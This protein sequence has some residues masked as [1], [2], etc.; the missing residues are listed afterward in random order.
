ML[1]IDDEERL[2]FYVDILK[3]SIRPNLETMR[4]EREVRMVRML[5][6]SMC[7]SVIDRSDSLESGV[8]VLWSHPQVV[9]ELR[10][11]FTYLYKRIDHIHYPLESHASA[12]MQIHGKYTR[13]EILGA[14]GVGDS[15]RTRPWREGVLWVENERADIFVFTLD[16]SEGNFSPTTMYRDYAISPELIHWESQSS[17]SAG[18]PTGK[19]YRNH[20][21]EGT[22]VM[23]FC[24]ESSD[25]RA[26]W[27][28]GPASYVSHESERPME[29]T[30]KL[31]S[32]LPGDLYARFAAAVA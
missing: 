1:H 16:K 22:S 26:F 19:R 23:L 2:D 3:P 28:L 5:V 12:P 4:T 8:A 11:L 7:D 21:A 6:A 31:S 18:S 14:F 32:P 30:W 20:L 17:T 25:D 29:I 15:A 13:I 24:R 9:A 27:F 10:E